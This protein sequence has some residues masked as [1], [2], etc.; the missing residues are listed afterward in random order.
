MPVPAAK[1]ILQQL[2]T[3]L[4]YCHA[5]GVLHRDLKPANVLLSRYGE[6]KLA[7]FGLARAVPPAEALV[8]PRNVVTAGYRAPE[9]LMGDTRYGPGVDTW[10]LG[11]MAY[12]LKGSG[13]LIHASSTLSEHTLLERVL[14]LF[15][16]P[17]KVLRALPGC[18]PGRAC[19]APLGRY[20]NSMGTLLGSPTT[21]QLADL[22]SALLKMNPVER[23]SAADVMQHPW[24]SPES[25][26]S[27][28][29]P[30]A[31]PGCSPAPY[32][33]AQP[34][35]KMM[36]LGSSRKEMRRSATSS[37]RSR[38]S[39]TLHRGLPAEGPPKRRVSRGPGKDFF[40]FSL[41]ERY[42]PSHPFL[43][44]LLS[45]ENGFICP[46]VNTLICGFAKTRACRTSKTRGHRV[47]PLL[48]SDVEACLRVVTPGARRP[49]TQRNSHSG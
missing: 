26:P 46:C 9:V 4:A 34:V 29:Q 16:E 49:V 12:E 21:P 48:Q 28:C 1:C 17:G 31:M 35:C 24:L 38:R 8:T 7:D 27:P 23:M 42:W 2:A 18:C 40:I 11:C 33:L 37:N 20:N 45:E 19:L 44:A 5:R 3:A 30:G 36:S 10:A 14:R 41:L 15:G 13:P 43:R 32:G 6:V 39:G 22:I 47:Q 25:K